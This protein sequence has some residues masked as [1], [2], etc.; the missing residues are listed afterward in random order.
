[1]K[2]LNV[3]SGKEIPDHVACDSLDDGLKGLE[4]GV[5][6]D[7][8]IETL[9][10]DVDEAGGHEGDEVG[11]CHRVA[12]G[13]ECEGVYCMAVLVSGLDVGIDG[14]GDMC[15]LEHVACHVSI[16]TSHRVGKISVIGSEFGR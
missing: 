9:T 10:A 12:G 5:V 4:K 6:H 7:T 14:V 8:E 16:D 15:K 13:G 3:C 2:G 1:M 11:G